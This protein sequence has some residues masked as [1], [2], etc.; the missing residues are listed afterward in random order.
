MDTATPVIDSYLAKIGALLRK[1]EST[2]SEPEAQAL[3]AKAQ[4]LASLHAI[5][6]AVARHYLPAGERREQ[7]I[8]REIRLGERGTK[9]LSTLVELFS[10]I[11]LA[12]DV[13]LT[14]AHNSTFVYA[15]GFPSDI[16]TV[17]T[18]YSSLVVQQVQAARAY[19]A[20]STWKSE[21]VWRE[22]HYDRNY[23]W[24]RGDYRP[25]SA[26]T[27]RLNFQQGFA[28][29][30]GDRLREAK[31][32]ATAER[33]AA[34]RKLFADALPAGEE[35][36]LSTSTALVLKGKTEELDA[37][38]VAKTRNIRG[39]YK[40]GSHASS[41]GARQAGA[42]AANSARLTPQRGIGR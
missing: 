17:E 16:D 36:V 34:E 7:P 15:H 8:V 2:D 4:Q 1:A 10:Q 24:Q 35:P 14:I 23:T 31:A 19:I 40:G 20:S 42:A 21:K 37:F 9:G 11:G 30:I 25:I 13:R 26:I 29:R 38:W 22:G 39:S 27:A 3:T 32:Q 41:S 12:N 6:L 5:D 28:Y 18:L 33:T